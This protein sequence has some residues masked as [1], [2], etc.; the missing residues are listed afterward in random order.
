MIDSDIE[1]VERGNEER[2]KNRFSE[3]DGVFTARELVEIS[4]YNHAFLRGRFVLGS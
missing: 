3:Q 2:R 1:E 4:E